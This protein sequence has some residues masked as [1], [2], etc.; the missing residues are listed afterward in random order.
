MIMDMHLPNETR[1]TSSLCSTDD[2]QR[3]TAQTLASVVYNGPEAIEQRLGQL[4]HEWSIG[5]LIKLF[6]GVGI[7][8]GLALAVFV[9]AAWIALPVVIGLLLI[10]YA[11]S[12]HSLLASPLRAAGFRTG[13]EIAHERIALKALRGDFRHLPPVYDKHDEDALARMA[14]EGGIVSG[15]PETSPHD[16][17]AVAHQV[18][19]ALKR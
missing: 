9:H 8:I 14:G 3:Q 6:T 12:R 1:S 7:F 18:L 5:Q 15:G 2:C 16:S 17:Q 11:V 10:Q 19:D 13:M 4:D